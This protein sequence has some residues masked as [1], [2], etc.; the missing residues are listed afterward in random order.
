VT[1]GRSDEARPLRRTRGP[2][3]EHG[4][5]GW[6]LGKLE[7]SVQNPDGS[8]RTFSVEVG[9]SLT[10]HGDY[11]HAEADYWTLVAEKLPQ[12]AERLRR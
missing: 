11:L 2:Q 6:A 7:S 12:I 3:R 10:P 5:L 1:G 9:I 8:L 4:R